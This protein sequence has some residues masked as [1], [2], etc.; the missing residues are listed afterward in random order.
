M[1]AFFGK[2]TNAGRVPYAL[3][4]HYRFNDQRQAIPNDDSD[5]F[6]MPK[7]PV[8]FSLKDSGAIG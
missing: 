1:S 2:D 7:N 6:E 8:M 3:L 5:P 4:L